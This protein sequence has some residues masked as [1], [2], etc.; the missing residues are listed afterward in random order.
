MINNVSNENNEIEQKANGHMLEN[1][2]SS[3]S[4]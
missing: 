3:R 4:L 1:Q 2:L